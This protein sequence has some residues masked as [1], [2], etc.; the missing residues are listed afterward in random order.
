MNLLEL[1][2]KNDPNVRVE[3]WD[4]QAQTW[5]PH[6]D[7]KSLTSKI[8]RPRL[9]WRGWRPR[10]DRGAIRGLLMP[11]GTRVVVRRASEY[12]PNYAR[13][14]G[15][16]KLAANGAAAARVEIG[17]AMPGAPQL[18]ATVNMQ[19]PRTL[20]EVAVR[21]A[22]GREL[23]LVIQPVRA[24]RGRVFVGIHRLLDRAEVYSLC[25]GA[26]V[27]IGPGPKP[28]ILPGAGVQVRYVEQATPDEWQRL[29]GK[30]TRVP[31]DPQLWNLYVIGNADR[32]PAEPGTLDFVFSSHVLEHLADP[33]GHLAYW[34]SLLK[35][36]GVVVAVI[37][38]KSGCKDYVFEESSLEELLREYEQ[39]ARAPTLA[40]YERWARFR[41]PHSTAAEIFASGRSI[42]VHFY[43]AGSMAAI[44]DRT[45]RTLGFRSVR[46]TSEPNH[47]DFFVVLRK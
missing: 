20:A 38:D 6:P 41:M 15:R 22:P 5:A 26:G 29:Y 27:E 36:G 4:E 23:D 19:A 34:A 13:G 17:W 32:I 11:A 2:A 7:A 18:Q 14:E 25:V 47:K 12:W 16:L 39:E 45:Y 28:Q 8:N 46:I 43:T 33:L 1:I 3:L 21:P 42:H 9:R 30:D 24:G 35:P 40:H 37:P 10:V 44:L 31:V